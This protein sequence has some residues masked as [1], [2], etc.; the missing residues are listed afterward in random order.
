MD[1]QVEKSSQR[2]KIILILLLTV[3]LIARLLIATRSL[4]YL[5][6]LTIPD[7]AYLSLTIARN[8]AHGLGP[9]Y[10]L[11]YTNGFQPLYVFMM[12]PVY[13]VFPHDLIIPIHISLIISAV[14]D[15]LALYFLL[16]MISLH[17]SSRFPICIVGAAWVFNP[18]VITTTLNGMETSLSFFFITFSFYRYYSFKFLSKEYGLKNM[19]TWGIILGLTILARIDNSFLVFIIAIMLTLDIFERYKNVSLVAVTL[20]YLLVGLGTVL[21]PWSLYSWM[22]S[23]DIYPVSGKAVRLISLA[24]LDN[25]SIGNAILIM[26]SNVLNL[27]LEAHQLLLISVA[28]LFIIF[29]LIKKYGISRKTLR[30][31]IARYHPILL[32]SAA[33]ILSYTCYIYT[34]WY[35]HRYLFPI[36]L[37][38]LVYLAVFADMYDTMIIHKFTRLFM[39][40][41]LFIL[42]IVGSIMPIEFRALYTSTDTTS[43]GYMNMGLWAKK[44]FK[45]GTIVGACQTGALGYFADNLRVINLD[46]VVNKACYESLEQRECIKYIKKSKIEYLIGWRSNIEFIIKQS[47]DIKQSD[48]IMIGEIPGFKSWGTEW[49]LWKIN[50]N[51]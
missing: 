50:Y 31:N 21:I 3:N 42:F 47:A 29:P 25:A 2:L 38:L 35:F 14:L 39:R 7:D 27:I 43:Q 22:Y 4:I 9:F 16:R 33:I 17:T 37:L 32:F 23:S 40:S 1:T 51:N 8:I 24:W 18:Y 13:W 12:V 30:I 44:H 19:F 10:G 34:P 49:H 41:I 46:G 45:D 15:T 5:D 36:I 20:T 6:G 28:G 48:L 11:D 26:F